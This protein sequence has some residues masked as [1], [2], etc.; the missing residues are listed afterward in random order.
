MAS[1]NV[2]KMSLKDL[3]DLEAKLTKAKAAVR[4][5][6]KS[7]AKQK[8]DAILAADR[9]AP[10][11]Q[12]HTAHRIWQRLLDEGFVRLNLPKPWLPF[13]EGGFPTPSGKCE[14]YSERMA[15][16]G[17]DPVPAYTPPLWQQT[18]EREPDATQFVCISPPAHSFLNSTFANMERFR[19]REERPVLRMHPADA[20][21]ASIAE[22]DEVRVY[23]ERGDV[24]LPVE[25]DTGLVP[26]TVLAPGVWWTKLSPNRRNINRV[27]SAQESEMGAGATF[28]DTL[29][30]LEVVRRSTAE[31][32]E[33][34]VFAD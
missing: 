2:D 9:Q 8:I 7:E 11:K 29:V 3:N 19:T 31:T 1:I 34:R 25:I 16:D 13:A 17:Y 26:G 30:R 10:R 6:A 4:N 18:L 24:L 33:A 12:R 32:T 15:A 23:N 5:R 20:A 14:F 21:T 22:G 27:T 28:Y